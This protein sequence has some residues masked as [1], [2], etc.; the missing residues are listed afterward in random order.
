MKQILFFQPNE[1]KYLVKRRELRA[2][3]K[4]FNS[5]TYIKGQENYRFER[6]FGEFIGSKNILALN[7]GTDALVV[8]MLSLGIKNGDE[9]IVPSHTATA[10]ISA[11]VAVGAVPVFV[12]IELNYFTLD[13]LKIKK[14]ISEKTKAIIAVH[15]YGLPCDI[16]SLLKICADNGIFLIEDCAQSCGAEYEGKK[17]GNFGDIAAFSFYPTKNLGAVGDAGALVFKDEYLIDKARKIAQYGW[18]SSRISQVRG[19]NSRMDEIQAAILNEK[20]KNLNSWNRRRGE[21]ATLYFENLNPNL[22][23]LP[24]IRGNSTHVF[25]LFVIKNSDRDNVINK[26]ARKKVSLGLHYPIPNHLHP[27]FQQ[28]AHNSDLEN[29]EKV[30]KEI[31]SIPIYPELT[32]KQVKRVCEVLNDI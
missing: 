5:K 11:I 22:Y 10:T 23:E 8:G 13:S 26:A 15:I 24:K 12:D 2:I 30:C 21:I 18:D 29:T 20:L 25:H 16:N 7:S 4:V 3:K 28:F 6:K 1:D 27:F 9:I 19:I 17:V 14:L 32:N 31:L